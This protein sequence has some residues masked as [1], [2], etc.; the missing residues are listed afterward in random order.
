MPAK[1]EEILKPKPLK[2][3]ELENEDDERVPFKRRHIW[4]FYKEVH[5]TFVFETC[6]LLHVKREHISWVY[7]CL[8]D[9]FWIIN[10]QFSC[11]TCNLE[12]VLKKT[13][14]A[15]YSCIIYSLP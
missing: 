2:I 1:I 10:E 9:T 13:P 7:C 11:G 8:Q 14:Y 3:H 12:C 4:A 6:W 5:P 15:W